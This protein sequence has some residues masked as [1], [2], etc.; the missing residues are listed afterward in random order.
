M[1]SYLRFSEYDKDGKEIDCIDPVENLE[2]HD[3]HYLVDNGYAVYRVEIVEGHT[4][5][6][7]NLLT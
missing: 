5:W 2:K 7:R 3:D 4:Y 6:T 1:H